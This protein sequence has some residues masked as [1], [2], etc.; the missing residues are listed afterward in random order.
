MVG[1]FLNLANYSAS[2][3]SFFTNNDDTRITI[4]LEESEKSEKQEKES[5]EKDDLIEK[6]KI[7]ELYGY[8]DAILAN[9]TLKRFPEEYLHVSS[10]YLDHT[11]PPPRYESI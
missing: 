10:I 11:T 4:T 9:L 8:K 6:D 2:M 5:S 1:F 3:I 7:P